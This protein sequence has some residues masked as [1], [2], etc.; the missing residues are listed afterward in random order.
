MPCLTYRGLILFA[1]L[2]GNL[3]YHIEAKRFQKEGRAGMLKGGR[4]WC[5]FSHKIWLWG[6]QWCKLG[7]QCAGHWVCSQQQGGEA[8][9]DLWS[10]RV[11]WIAHFHWQ[12]TLCICRVWAQSPGVSGGC[13]LS[14]GILI[15]VV[16]LFFTPKLQTK[17]KAFW[18]SQV[19]EK[20]RSLTENGYVDMPLYLL[21]V[22]FLQGDGI[23]VK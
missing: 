17:M 15:K 6:H 23:L 20:Y 7:G 12:E 3:I 14:L 4:E 1:Q 5:S 21:T 13:H 18:I 11:A 10:Q 8:V 22:L 16:L 19:R 2:E 9:T